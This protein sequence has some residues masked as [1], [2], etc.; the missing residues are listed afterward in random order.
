MS[1]SFARLALMFKTNFVHIILPVDPFQIA[2]HATVTKPLKNRSN[3]SPHGSM[4]V[5]AY[6][7][8]S[9]EDETGGLPHVQGQPGL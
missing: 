7:P 4:V 9:G 5:P 2:V 8:S 1:F 6:N 3:Y